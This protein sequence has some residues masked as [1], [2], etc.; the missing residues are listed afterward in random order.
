[1]VDEWSVSSSL[2]YWQVSSTVLPSESMTYSHV[3]VLCPSRV[4]NTYVLP[5]C[6]NNA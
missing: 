2:Q 4:F 5:A 1:M 6:A 3:K